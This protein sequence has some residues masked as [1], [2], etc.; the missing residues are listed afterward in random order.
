MACVVRVSFM[1]NTITNSS[2]KTCTANDHA[3]FTSQQITGRPL[4]GAQTTHKRLSPS[5][6]DHPR[7]SEKP[8]DYA[9]DVSVS[10]CTAVLYNVKRFTRSL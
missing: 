8:R 7:C 5:L 4:L 1:T 6:R 10:D 3:V 2:S 9:I